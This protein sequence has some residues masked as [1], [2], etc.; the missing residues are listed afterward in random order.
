M[1]TEL[2]EQANRDETSRAAEAAAMPHADLNVLRGALREDQQLSRELLDT[3]RD[4]FHRMR[5]LL[6][7]KPPKVRGG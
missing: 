6:S 1:V 3:T 4:E 7:S 5:D 2:R